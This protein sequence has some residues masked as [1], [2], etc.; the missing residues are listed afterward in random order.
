M[1]TSQTRTVLLR[2]G[3]AFLGRWVRGAGNVGPDV[4]ACARVNYARLADDVAW[5]D[6]PTNRLVLAFFILPMASLYKALLEAGRAQ[7][8]AVDSVTQAVVSMV[9]IERGL[10]SLLV[11]SD[12]GRRLYLRSWRPQ[13]RIYFPPP[14][15]QVSLHEN[16]GE[17][18]VFDVTR[19]YVVETLQALDAAEVAPAFCTYDE[20]MYEGLCPRLRFT[21]TGTLATGAARCDF[22]FENL[23]EVVPS[24][25]TGNV[26]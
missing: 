13:L 25:G 7:S 10:T 22:C 9:G 19:C 16:T 1:L 5:P 8:E 6:E 11:R 14:S 2:G 15:W 4:E 17:R 3:K 21:R 23:R 26:A 20:A 18:V 12:L 24:V